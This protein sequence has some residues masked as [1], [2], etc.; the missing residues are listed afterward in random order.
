MGATIKRV[1]EA[2]GLSQGA[3]AERAK[4]TRE[5]LNRLEAGRYDPTVG[6]L[7]RIARAL[8]VRAVEL[9]EPRP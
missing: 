4:L 8:G 5:H 2:K 3:L 7:Q 9:L 6:T 1:R